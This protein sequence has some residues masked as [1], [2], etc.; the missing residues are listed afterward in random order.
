MSPV[1]PGVKGD[2]G[3]DILVAG[4]RFGWKC[5][6]GQCAAF[7]GNVCVWLTVLIGVTSRHDVS[8]MLVLH[9]PASIGVRFRLLQI[10]SLGSKGKVDSP[11]GN[12]LFCKVESSWK[13]DV[14][15]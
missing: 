4:V 3:E 2:A 12:A 8:C 10:R 5:T 11:S 15:D 7:Y 13:N 14:G 1:G 9:N 6:K